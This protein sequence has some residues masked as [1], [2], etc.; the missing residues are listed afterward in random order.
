MTTRARPDIFLHKQDTRFAKGVS[1]NPAGKPKG[2]R[3]RLTRALDELAAADA[4]QVLGKSL[5]L[6]KDGDVAAAR[7]I[8]G[9]AWP[10]PRGRLVEGLELPVMNS[11]ADAVAA[12]GMIASAVTAGT[13]TLEEARDL[14]AIIEAFRRMH[15]L[16]EIERRI[17]ALERGI[18]HAAPYE[19]G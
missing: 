18:A 6:A 7:M 1:G 3:N 5:E 14:T 15:E 2:T 9:R 8:L 11:A 10:K 17:T 19:Q 4:V 12:M 16:A 13:L